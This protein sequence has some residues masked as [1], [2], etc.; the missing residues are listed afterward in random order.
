IIALF[1]T[2]H[3]SLASLAPAAVGL[4]V[5]WALNAR[6]VMRPA[7]YI[8]A[9]IFIWV[10]VLRSGVHATLAG[11]VVALAIPLKTDM[12]EQSSLLEHLEENLHPWIALAVLPLFAFAN[13]GVSLHGLSLAKLLQPISLGIALGLFPGKMLGI[14]GA[15]WLAIA[16]GL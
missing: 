8:L 13:A 9:G 2:E 16:T 3:L 1:Y 6:A 14:L 11:V 7:P 4:A 5:L 15:T 10:C 12:P